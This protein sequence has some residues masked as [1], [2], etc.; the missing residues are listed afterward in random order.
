MGLH[1]WEPD[2][3]LGF[4]PA[5]HLQCTVS[6]T[7]FFSGQENL[8]SCFHRSHLDG[9]VVDG[10]RIGKRL[11]LNLLIIP[12]GVLQKRV[13]IL[14]ILSSAKVFVYMEFGLVEELKFLF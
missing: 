13:V 6:K 5:L 7:L 9:A 8:V 14:D 11:G 12:I 4:S 1:K 2:I 3:Y 10:L